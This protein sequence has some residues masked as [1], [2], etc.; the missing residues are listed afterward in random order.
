MRQDKI[1]EQL[2]GK[3]FVY[4]Y[5]WSDFKKEI[6]VTCYGLKIQSLFMFQQYTQNHIFVDLYNMI[7]IVSSAFSSPKIGCKFT[8]ML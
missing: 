7:S 3:T 2:F 5:D 4:I 6:Y 8:L 1:E